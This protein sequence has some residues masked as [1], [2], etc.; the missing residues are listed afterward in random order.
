M[1]CE[2]WF[3]HTEGSRKGSVRLADLVVEYPHDP[4]TGKPHYVSKLDAE[5]VARKIRDQLTGGDDR[6]LALDL[7]RLRRVQALSANDIDFEIEWSF[8]GLVTD[9]DGHPV[10]GVCEVDQDALPDTALICVNPEAI[11]YRDELMLSTAWHELGHAIFEAPSWIMASRKASEESAENTANALSSRV[12]RTTTYDEDHFANNFPKG[13]DEF[14]QE[15]RANCFMG[16]ALTPR[17]ELTQRFIHHCNEVGL[18]PGSLRRSSSEFII[19]SDDASAILGNL[20]FL[21]PVAMRYQLVIVA[22]SE[23]FRVSPRFI[24]VRLQIYGLSNKSREP[25][26]Y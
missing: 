16:S 8:D 26:I 4:T 5:R 9:D 20:N 15:G 6:V 14:F 18:Q 22:L 19:R 1:T 12:Y 7:D 21:D 13:S 25:I 23:E 17:H 11:H 10:L 2:A 24:E 3:R